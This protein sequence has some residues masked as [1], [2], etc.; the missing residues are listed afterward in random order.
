MAKTNQCRRY[1]LAEI[2]A[3]ERE[4]FKNNPR[5][6]VPRREVIRPLV[7]YKQVKDSTGRL[8]KKRVAR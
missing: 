8:K 3:F 7:K 2:A 5:V 1:T 4:Y 6:H